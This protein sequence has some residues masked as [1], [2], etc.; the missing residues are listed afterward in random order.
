MSRACAGSPSNACPTQEGEE[1]RQTASWTAK[2]WFKEICSRFRGE[3][4][5]CDGASVPC[6]Q[7]RTSKHF[8]G[9][10]R[11]AQDLH[12]GRPHTGGDV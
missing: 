4:L 10:Q 5:F 2:H 9:E 1:D 12:R 8:S 11:R 7:W 3:S 6:P